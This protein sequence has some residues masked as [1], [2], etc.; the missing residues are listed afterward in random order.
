MSNENKDA[1]DQAIE[2]LDGILD[3]LCGWFTKKTTEIKE[4]K[5]ENEENQQE[6]K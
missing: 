5:E 2:T 4:K 3:G 1:V 6:D